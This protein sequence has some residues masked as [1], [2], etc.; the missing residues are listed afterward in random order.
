M[1]PA[2]RTDLRAW[3]T[4]EPLTQGHASAGPPDALLLHP[5]SV[6]DPIDCHQVN[7]AGSQRV[8]E[9]AR[10]QGGAHVVLASSAAVHCE[11]DDQPSREDRPVAR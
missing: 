9:T 10:Q 6:E 4:A 8:L 11:G 3:P 5:G 2:Q 1:A 7:T